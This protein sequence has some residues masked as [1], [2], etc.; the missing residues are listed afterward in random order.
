MRIFD[1]FR[2]PGNE[3]TDAQKKWNQ[4]WDLWEKGRADTPYA[5]SMT[6]QSEINNGGHDQY[7]F[8]L[9]NTGSLQ[10]EIA[11]LETVLPAKLKKNLLDAYD[12][13][14][15]L[16]DEEA[17]QQAETILRPY[18][19]AFY[20]DEEEINCILRRYASEMK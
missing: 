6:Y 7:F 20:K 11:A 9:E 19:D 4:L 16:T 3:L 8:N 17:D 2:K 15:K 12:A 1:F 18:D 14:T 5:E 13:Y 10:R